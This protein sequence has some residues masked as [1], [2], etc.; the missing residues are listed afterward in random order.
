MVIGNRRDCEQRFATEA[1]RQFAQ[2]MKAFE[3]AGGLVEE[4]DVDVAQ[5]SNRERRRQQ[6]QHGGPEQHSAAVAHGEDAPRRQLIFEKRWRFQRDDYPGQRNVGR[7]QSCSARQVL[8]AKC[9]FSA[10]F[11]HRY[12][13]DLASIFLQASA[14][15]SHERRA[16]HRQTLLS[17]RRRVR[18]EILAT[19]EQAT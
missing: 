16:Y 2:Q 8:F 9:Y 5:R 3:I 15:Y 17:R 14:S 10:N 1:F 4:I 12:F 6:P 19:D 11:D 13:H 7:L 18:P